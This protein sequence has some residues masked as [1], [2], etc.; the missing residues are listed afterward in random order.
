MTQLIPEFNQE[1]CLN[2][3]NRNYISHILAVVACKAE[4]T[5]D[6]EGPVTVSRGNIVTHETKTGEPSP[7]KLTWNIMIGKPGGPT[8]FS[9]TDWTSKIE[10]GED[11][12][13]ANGEEVLYPH[14]DGQEIH[15]VDGKRYAAFI[16][17]SRAGFEAH[18]ILRA[19]SNIYT[20]P[21]VGEASKPE[22]EATTINIGYTGFKGKRN[23]RPD[24]PAV[25]K[26]INKK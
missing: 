18:G 16:K 13:K 26:T 22:V 3:P 4:N 6:C 9:R 2:C 17:G 12:I 15:V 24:Y 8:V 19:F 10:C 23:K 11:E 1:R 5:P 20:D 14:P 25:R 7:D 21:N